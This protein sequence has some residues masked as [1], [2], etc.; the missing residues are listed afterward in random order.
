VYEHQKKVRGQFPPAFTFERTMIGHLIKHPDDYLGALRK[1]FTNFL[2]MFIHAYQSHFFNEMLT[3]RCDMKIPPNEAR[4]GDIVLAVDIRGVPDRKRRI[5]VNRNNIKK[6]QRRIDEGKA[7]ITA[8]AI[9]TEV[10]LAGGIQGEIEREVLS[11]RGVERK[12]FTIT[13]IPRIS[14]KGIRRE[15]VAPVKKFHCDIDE[16]RITLKF[17]LYKGCYATSLLREFMKSENVRVY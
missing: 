6:I 8:V 10:E 5:P 13:E 1:L 15:I 12:D 2:L 7:Y 14:S 11:E 9:G 3:R 16:D 17:D 4:V